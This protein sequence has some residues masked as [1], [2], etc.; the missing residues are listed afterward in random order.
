MVQLVKYLVC[1]KSALLQSKERANL[2]Y[3]LILML[4]ESAHLT[5]YPEKDLQQF[6]DK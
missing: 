4:I 1:V 2:S 3:L 6:L 5:I